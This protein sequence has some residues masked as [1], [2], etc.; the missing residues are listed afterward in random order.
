ME[1]ESVRR[2]QV[3]NAVGD[4]ESSGVATAYESHGFSVLC[5]SVYE[6]S[7]SEPRAVAKEDQPD[8]L[9]IDPVATS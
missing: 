9:N 7:A 5:G 2:L 1:K 3:W 4:A 6:C 8:L